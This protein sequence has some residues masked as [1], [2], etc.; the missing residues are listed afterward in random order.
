MLHASSAK[1]NYAKH[2]TS[3]CINSHPSKIFFAPNLTFNLNLNTCQSPLTTDRVTNTL[4]HSSSS[5]TPLHFYS[6]STSSHP[7]TYTL[8]SS[9]QFTSLFFSSHLIF[10]Y[11]VKFNFCAGAVGR[12]PFLATLLLRFSYSVLCIGILFNFVITF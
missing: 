9:L 5:N 2:V 11:I 12:Q 10:A 6:D 3:K 1:T 4:P 8:T 7:L